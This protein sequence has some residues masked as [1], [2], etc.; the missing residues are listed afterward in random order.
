MRPGTSH[1][2]DDEA[3]HSKRGS[4]ALVVSGVGID[5]LADVIKASGARADQKA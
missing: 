5:A 2:R 3:R 4:R 1:R